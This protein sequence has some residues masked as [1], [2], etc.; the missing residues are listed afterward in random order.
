MLLCVFIINKCS[1]TCVEREWKSKPSLVAPARAASPSGLA[2]SE[3]VSIKAQIRRKTVMSFPSAG[4][5][6]RRCRLYVCCYFS[7]LTNH[8]HENHKPLLR[9]SVHSLTRLQRF[10]FRMNPSESQEPVFTSEPPRGS[11]SS[12]RFPREWISIIPAPPA[13]S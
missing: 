13:P 2:P 11:C 10:G 3:F 6:F 12:D 9:N 5:L 8:F 7:W 4:V 1:V